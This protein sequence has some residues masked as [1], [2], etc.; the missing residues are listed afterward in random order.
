MSKIWAYKFHTREK[1]HRNM[2]GAIFALLAKSQEKLWFI[3]CV[4]FDVQIRPVLADSVTYYKA[5][6]GHFLKNSYP[7]FVVCSISNSC[8]KLLKCQSVL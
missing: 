1:K 7:Q 8:D 4:E 5:T 6:V 3:E 2:S